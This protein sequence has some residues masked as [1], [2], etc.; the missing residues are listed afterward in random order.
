MR[1][2]RDFPGELIPVNPNA[3]TIAGKR[4]F[5]SLSA[6]GHPTDL[7]V[8]ALPAQAA[9]SVLI[10]GARAG[11]RSAVIISGGFAEA[12]ETRAAAQA[13]IRDVCRE[14][15]IRLLGPNT[16][17]FVFDCLNVVWLAVAMCT[18]R[19]DSLF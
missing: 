7:A 15:G 13:R 14:S 4:A 1:V 16:S 3:A 12:G 17:G 2:L 5:P 8:L 19:S 11:L 9:E 6:I 18:I 10:D